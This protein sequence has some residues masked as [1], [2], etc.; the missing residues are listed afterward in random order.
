MATF[1]L[2]SPAGPQPAH[3]DLIT[4]RIP[5]WLTHASADDRAAY[6]QALKRN[7]A[8]AAKVAALIRRFKAPGVFAES[9]LSAAIQARFNLDIDVSSAQWVQFQ[10]TYQLDRRVTSVRRRTLLEAAMNNF[11]ADEPFDGDTLLLPADALQLVVAENFGWRYAP[12]KVLAIAPARFAELCRSLDLGQA[13]QAHFNTVFKP[14]DGSKAWVRESLESNI[15]EEL[16]VQAHRA[17]LRG[18]IAA[19]ERQVLLDLVAEPE[20]ATKWNGQ[21]VVISSLQ[22]LAP[23]SR[24][25]TPC[26][27]CA[28]FKPALRPMLLA[29]FTCQVSPIPRSRPTPVSLS[30]PTTCA[31]DCGAWGMR[32]ILGGSSPRPT[33]RRSCNA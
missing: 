20:V 32:T 17:M 16:T 6:H 26:R 4:Q 11:A 10:R 2:D 21:P 23:G 22:A 7:Q 19:D 3:L 9:V 31:S 29:S 1:D 5:A 14:Q 13:Y 25:V 27:A 15:R 8:A 28:S 24:T 30:S 18:D 33:D 12:A